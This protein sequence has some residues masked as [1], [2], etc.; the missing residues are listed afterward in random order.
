METSALLAL[1]DDFVRQTDVANA[2]A[3]AGLREK[4]GAAATA[5]WNLRFH[6]SGDV[7]RRVDPYLPFAL[8]LRRWIDSFR[9]LGIQFRGATLQLDL[10][11]RAGKHQNGFCHGP[12]PSWVTETG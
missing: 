12:V 1:L 2:R 10:L 11:E 8:A 3:L 5:P 6:A 9:R 7:I 4:H